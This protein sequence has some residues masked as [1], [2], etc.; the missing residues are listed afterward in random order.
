MKVTFGG[1][2]IRDKLLREARCLRDVPEEHLHPLFIVP[3]LTPK[4]RA[5]D[6]RLRTELKARKDQGESGLFIKRGKIAKKKDTGQK[7]GQG[8]RTFWTP[9]QAMPTE[10]SVEEEQ[11]AEEARSADASGA[12]V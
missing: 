12:S 5:E 7:S 4:E 9:S 8:G 10:T 1:K 11:S 3:D 6:L 2:E